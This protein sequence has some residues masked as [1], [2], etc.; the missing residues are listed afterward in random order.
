MLHN[1]TMPFNLG[2]SLV[3]GVSIRSHEIKLK[4]FKNQ[5]IQEFSNRHNIRKIYHKYDVSSNL[6]SKHQ[7]LSNGK[8]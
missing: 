7:K 4:L 8:K 3:L 2:L 6:S 5:T 1:I